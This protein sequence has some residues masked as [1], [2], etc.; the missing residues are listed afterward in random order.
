MKTQIKTI[1]EIGDSASEY[2]LASE[3]VSRAFV[4]GYRK[5]LEDLKCPIF[6]RRCSITGEGMNEGWV[7]DGGEEY[8]KYEVH[9]L[10]WCKEMGYDSIEDAYKSEDFYY[11]EWFLDEEWG[12][13][14]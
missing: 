1:A 13:C 10:A 5:A 6:A 12:F 9:A 3:D 2:L 8:F 14:I 7:V 11:T 4:E